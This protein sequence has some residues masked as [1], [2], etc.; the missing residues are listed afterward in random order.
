MTLLAGTL[1]PTF[2]TSTTSYT[3]TVANSMATVALTPTLAHAKATV[4]VGGYDVASG[5]A[6]PQLA[7]AEGAS[8]TMSVVVTPQC[9]TPT[10]TYSFVVTRAKSTVSTLADVLLGSDAV[11]TPAFSSS[12]TSYTAS[13]ANSVNSITVTP[14]TT[15][16]SAAVTVSGASVTSGQESGG[17]SLTVGG[18]V[19]IPVV[20]TAQDGTTTKTYTV[21]I[22][23]QP[24]H[25]DTLSGLAIDAGTI[26]PAFSSTTL[27]YIVSVAN[28]VALI[29]LTATA[30]H[31][32]ASIANVAGVAITSGVQSSGL[33]V[34]EGGSDVLSVV[35]TAQD[36]TSVLTYKVTVR[37]ACS[38]EATLSNLVPNHGTLSPSFSSG[39]LSYSDSVANGWVSVTLTPTTTH[40]KATVR[41]GGY[42]VVSGQASADIA[43]F[44]G[45]SKTVLVVVTPQCGTPTKTYSFVVTRAKSDNAELAALTLSEDVHL[46]PAFSSSTEAYTGAVDN[47]VAAVS[48]TGTTAHAAATLTV[49]GSAVVSG[50][51][52]V[53]ITLPEGTPKTVTV[54]VTAQDGA[55]AKTYTVAITRQPS[56]VC[57]LA[58]LSSDTG[59]W[60]PVFSPALSAYTN[61]ITATSVKAIL[62]HAHHERLK[63]TSWS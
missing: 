8:R 19:S 1:S 44:E 29:K 3:D 7:L 4:Q 51:T 28:S 34:T 41:V 23:R 5:Q 6:S 46:A 15:H 25:D 59:S 18:T 9:G 32:G 38:V 36:G 21:A 12:T 33:T 43:L 58:A 16:A 39:T 49:E 47:S 40:A 55:T 54:V 24:S 10:K 56:H 60:S 45:S 37:R 50:Q 31:S 61:S 2:Q 22:T 17:V 20:V 11:L 62:T 63:C 13:V 30:T 52:S 27:E 48:I 53:P 14:S 26:T 42:A 35:V 57:S